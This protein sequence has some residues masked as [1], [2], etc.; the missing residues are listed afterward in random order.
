VR[1]RRARIAAFFPALLLLQVGIIL[2]ASGPKGQKA[3]PLDFK[4]EAEMLTDLSPGEWIR[5]G[6]AT[7]V[8]LDIQGS[9]IQFALE[10][11]DLEPNVSK[12][13]E[14]K[15]HGLAAR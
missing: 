3:L 6:D 11:V 13:S 14:R 8:V 12:E 5:V 9:R 15:D 10:G 4:K 1:I 2:R 7:L